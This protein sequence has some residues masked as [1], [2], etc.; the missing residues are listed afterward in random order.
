LADPLNSNLKFT[1]KLKRSFWII[2]VCVWLAEAMALRAPLDADAVSYLDMANSFLSGNWHALVNGYWSPG[3]PFLLACELKLFHLDRFHQLLAI[4]FLSFIT[5]IIAL[6]CFECF[7]SSFIV[8]RR[9]LASADDDNGAKTIT[10]NA[11]RLIGYALFFWITTFFT[12]PSL[13][14][15]D[16]LV[17]IAYLLASALAMQL[18]TQHE[19]WR[20]ALL[21]LVLGFGYF[22]K[23]VMFPLG[24][25]F[26]FGLYVQARKCNV[27]TRVLFAFAIFL[28]VSAPYVIV[29]SNSKGHLTFS[30]VGAIAYRHIMGFDAGP[31]PP[32][33][34]PRPAA[35]PH[36]S[37]YSKIIG[38]GT[39]PPWADPSY[40]FKR[41]PFQF[42]L[43]RQ[44]NR[45]HVVLAGYFETYVFTLAG[46]SATLLILFFLNSPTSFL[47]RFLRQPVLWVPALTG[48][49]FYAS[50]RFENRFLGGFTLSLYAA[51]L[52]AARIPD[53]PLSAKFIKSVAIAAFVL[54]SAQAG[55]RAGH[56]AIKTFDH[57]PVPDAQV[58]VALHQMHVADGDCVAFMGDALLDHGW[59]YIA[60]TKIVAEVPPED[61]TNFWAADASQKQDVLAWLAS[62]GAKAVV[63]H[64]V[65]DTAMA[66]GWQRVPQTDYYLLPLGS[67]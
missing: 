57:S 12:P 15:P 50:M 61:I 17:F 31:L 6:V 19:W 28:A 64:S 30:D 65:P 66:M 22:A 41:G 7:L 5:L 11:V 62:T 27:S 29:L 60:G 26:L 40:G 53:S 23:S 67:R 37:E 58:A 33:P 24:F 9:R 1:P 46:L 47:G 16:I 63:T 45:I 49:A 51:W 44:L 10:D 38:L 2:I 8:F 18:L 59:A 4:Q 25:A 14:H 56:E 55:M 39:Y 13:Q 35:A 32:T 21:G 52:G 3:Y 54:L 43:S 48:L 20:F 36:V 34:I 42:S